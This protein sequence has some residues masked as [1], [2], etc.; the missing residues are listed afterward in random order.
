[1]HQTA[2]RETSLALDCHV[3]MKWGLRYSNS[4]I[5]TRCFGKKAHGHGKYSLKL[6]K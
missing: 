6:W 4:T 1:M 2:F 3:S 5:T